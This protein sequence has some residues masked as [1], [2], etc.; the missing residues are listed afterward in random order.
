M[1]PRSV[2]YEAINKALKPLGPGLGFASDQ[3]RSG[4][5]PFLRW[6]SSPSSEEKRF[7]RSSFGKGRFTVFKA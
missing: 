5:G 4:C 1:I 2:H 3:D 7:G 6:L